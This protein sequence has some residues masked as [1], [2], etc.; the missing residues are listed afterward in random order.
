MSPNLK[1]W[2]SIILQCASLITII[3]SAIKIINKNEREW[4][5]R[6]E[7]LLRMEAD[8]NSM[9]GNAAKL[10]AVESKLSDLLSEMSR[11]RD[12]LD[13]FLDTQSS[14]RSKE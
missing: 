5:Q 11:V 2:L 13:R 12:R 4:I 3:F 6:E 10:V 8:I 7:R 9:Q 1:D 14:S